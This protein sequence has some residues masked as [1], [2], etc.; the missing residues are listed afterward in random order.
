M[1]LQERLRMFEELERAR[2]RPLIVYATSPRLSAPST[3]VS[4]Q[5]MIGSDVIPY[6]LDQ[7]AALPSGTQ[8]V[9]ILIVSNGGDANTAWRII[10]LVRERINS[11]GVLVPQAAFSAAT[12]LAL[13][14]NEILMHPHGNLGPVDPQIEVRRQRQG[15]Q[16]QVQVEQLNFGFEELTGF[17]EYARTQLGLTDQEHL[18]ALFE[19]FCDAVG[20]VPVGMAARSSRL[21]MSLGQ[22]LLQ[23][24]MTS[25]QDA[26]KAKTIASKLNKEFFSHGYPVGRREARDLGLNVPELSS[27]VEGCMWRIWEDIE[28]EFQARKFFD[29]MADL[30]ASPPHASAL[31][32]PVQQVG[33]PSNLPPPLLQQVLQNLQ[34]PVTSLTPLDFETTQ[35]VVE[36]RRRASHFVTRGKILA[37][38]LPDLNIIANVV[39]TELGWQNRNV[40]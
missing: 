16:G 18:R 5:G 30:L 26:E 9:D 38:R 1:G 35:A 36:S 6:L 2:D 13:G 14:A 7:L 24:H 4:V 11:I 34:I 25:P 10:S 3:H 32:G 33:L 23:M 22:R 39:P 19:K 15:Q 27:E 31:F 29:P 28:N 21:S 37:T 12:L 20:P 8:G 40:S 17:V